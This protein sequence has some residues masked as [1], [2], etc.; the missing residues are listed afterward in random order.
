MRY[1]IKRDRRLGEEKWEKEESELE[2]DR[3]GEIE[4]IISGLGMMKVFSS[5]SVNE[6]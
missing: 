6:W 2:D 1:R 5:F 4:R 3:E